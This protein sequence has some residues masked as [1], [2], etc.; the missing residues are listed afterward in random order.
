M[1]TSSTTLAGSDGSW[2]GRLSQAAVTVPSVVTTATITVTVA[3]TGQ[4]WERRVI[5]I[6]H[7]F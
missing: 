6:V 5:V 4:G 3:L 7:P 2:A 1:A